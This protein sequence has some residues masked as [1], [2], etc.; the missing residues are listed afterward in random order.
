M[1]IFV[2]LISAI[3]F[4]SNVV[5]ADGLRCSSDGYTVITIN[6]VLTD[7]AGARKNKDILQNKLPPFYNNE[8]VLV[9][10]L[11]NP[12]HVGGLGDWLKA[13][14]QKVIE[15]FFNERSVN[16]YDLAKMIQDASEKVK[17]QKLLLVAHSQGNFYA[18][19]FYDAVVNKKGGVPA[20]SL[21][22]YGVATP[23]SRVAGGGSYLT[24]S[25]D[26]VITPIPLILPPNTRIEEVV[27]E[28]NPSATH[29]F[30]DVYLK[31]RGDAIVSNTI[32]A[33]ER[34]K[35]NDVQNAQGPC[36]DPLN[37]T[38]LNRVEGAALVTLDAA[39]S[40]VTIG[41]AAQEYIGTGMGN[42]FVAFSMFTGNAVQ[43]VGTA[44][45]DAVFSFGKFAFNSVKQGWSTGL[46][47]LYG[48]P[49]NE[50]AA[51]PSVSA[52]ISN[53]EPTPVPTPLAQAIEVGTPV[54][55]IIP[56]EERSTEAVPEIA[57]SIEQVV[58]ET[59]T[60][61][62]EVP[63]LA[64][65][66]TSTPEVVVM[67]PAP[68]Y[69]GG[70]W[71]SG[72]SPDSTSSPQAD[73]VAATDEAPTQETA[74]TTEETA[75]STDETATTTEEA[76]TT[77]TTTEEVAY[78][79]N[80]VVINEIA[81]MGTRAQVN[82]E[83][84]ELYNRTGQD[85]DLAGWTLASRNG[86]L[87]IALGSTISAHGY[88]LLERTN[89]STTDQ[90]QNMTYTGALNNSGP[91]A[92]LYLKNGTTTV[93]FV[94][95]GYWPAGGNAGAA[96]RRTMERV[97]PYADG[98]NISNW[99]TYSEAS[100]VPF[101][102]DAGNNDILGTPGA[103]NSVSG[104]Y[105]PAPSS[106]A[107]DTFWR[108]GHGPYYIPAITTI[109]SDATLTIEPGVVVKF[110]K[111]DRLGGGL[112]VNGVLRAEGTQE[113]PIV[114]T[115]SADDAADGVDTDGDGP[116][117]PQPADWKGITF[118]HPT[119]PSVL[120]YVQMRYGG[121]GTS[122]HPSGWFPIYTG[123]VVAQSSSPE[124]SNS[125]FASSTA[126]GLY[127]V[128]D[129]RPKVVQS[130]FGD[131]VAP[132]GA[133]VA[134]VGGVGIRLA[135]ASSTAEIIGNTFERSTIGIASRSASAA[136]LVVRDNTFRKNQR[137]AEFYSN[138]G[139]LNLDN[140][141]NRDLDTK[142]GLHI[143]FRVG[144]GR[145]VLLKADAMPYILAGGEFFTIDAGG[146]LTIEPG[147]VLK[148]S[149]DIHEVRGVLQ[150][151]GTAENPIIFTSLQDDSDGYDSDGSGD[152]PAAGAWENI[153]F[154]GASSS[155]SVLEYVHIR[156]GGKGRMVCGGGSCMRYYGAAHIDNASPTIAQC[157]FDNNLAVAVFIEGE[158]R[159]GIRD[160]E[161]KN[162]QDGFGISVGLESAPVL[163][164]NT[165]SGNVQDIV[166]R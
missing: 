108:A 109:A 53:I 92:N 75:T 39:A 59:A 71:V 112:A 18:N 80:P 142:G 164:N 74:T 27:G 67:P 65:A 50:A 117:E 81:W 131:M 55:V 32:V 151:R 85:I 152:A 62:E 158:S 111:R 64:D 17:T 38:L 42:G 100:T 34:L 9:D 83:W 88:F 147:T 119:A 72:I 2:F 26:L 30:S 36:I 82:D 66:A 69:A 44:L 90:M 141:G 48:A 84:I 19:G 102:K 110:A 1:R 150:A 25:S 87:H 120:S 143:A 12:S 106:I 21:G 126:A 5:L 8:P 125:V 35:T 63:A 61:T 77:A 60:S 99:L 107:K 134:Y 154:V 156:Y 124:I 7:D 144:E 145:S 129:S 146:T 13:G 54:S 166:Y 20:E 157:V 86:V 137:N 11:L 162:T 14:Y 58:I 140:S 31:Y 135:D 96:A 41:V 40:L 23:A 28:L 155:D 79:P 91:E 122:Y 148:N 149:Y 70:G 101:A 121:Q 4:A 128:G 93:D 73:A 94:D 165:Y 160:S 161:I 118:L 97:S 136:P 10:Y 159:P 22:V 37:L 78:D 52:P 98:D 56:T 43:S 57:T 33:L 105:I 68:V 16:D 127:V 3:F 104:R 95:F 132:S 29:N 139:W 6:G 76:I 47:L 46:A 130:W 138:T 115:S 49:A 153:R 15:Q 163:E 123:M 113:R 133:D 24:S 45:G 103:Q 114:F 116:T 89:A 51:T